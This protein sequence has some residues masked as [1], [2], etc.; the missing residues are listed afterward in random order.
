MP[1]RSPPLPS[2]K[3]ADLRTGDVLLYQGTALVSRLI[4]L[5]DRPVARESAKQARYSHASLWDGQRVLEALDQG[6]VA[7]PLSEST[8]GAA[9]VHV[10]RF[11]DGSGADITSPPWSPAPLLAQTLYYIKRADRYAYEQIFLLAFLAATRTASARLP[12]LVRQTMRLVL[13]DGAARLNHVISRGQQP[14]ICSELVYRCFVA[15]APP[16]PIPIRGASIAASLTTG[17]AHTPRLTTA[18][19]STDPDLAASA[20]TFISV[21]SRVDPTAPELTFSKASGKSRPV[22][23]DFVTPNDLANSP[24]L[25]C[26]GQLV[27]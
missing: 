23:P 1:S 14:L 3:P 4:L 27:S 13:D 12:A 25:H 6:V 11:K 24:G 26:V 16:Y 22:V 20:R 8:Q 5:F 7:R 9:F 10:Y 21:L 2:L 18:L 17:R 15:A 19:E